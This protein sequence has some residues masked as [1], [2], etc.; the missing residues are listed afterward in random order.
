[1]RGHTLA[2]II[3]HFAGAVVTALFYARVRAGRACADQP[4][5]RLLCAPRLP[6]SLLWPPPEPCA[7]RPPPS[8]SLRLQAWAVGAFAAFFALFSCLPAALEALTLLYILRV[9]AYSY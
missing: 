7:E 5:R 3:L 8:H 1:M 4:G 9:S 6:P 2:Y